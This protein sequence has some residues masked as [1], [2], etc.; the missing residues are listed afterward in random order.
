MRRTPFKVAL[1]L[2]LSASLAGCSGL[3]GSREPAPV[4]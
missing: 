3:L 2:A 4:T 1:T